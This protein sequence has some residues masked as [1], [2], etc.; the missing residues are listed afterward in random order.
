[1][2]RIQRF[3]N[4]SS[5]KQPAARQAGGRGRDARALEQ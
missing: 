3:E 5:Q 4:E 2:R 1:M